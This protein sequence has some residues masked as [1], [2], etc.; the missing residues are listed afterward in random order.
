MDGK[1]NKISLLKVGVWKMNLDDIYRQLNEKERLVIDG[2]SAAVYGYI[3]INANDNDENT[4]R[5]EHEQVLRI[6]QCVDS[7]WE[8]VDYDTIVSEI[9]DAVKDKVVIEDLMAEV[10]KDMPLNIVRRIHNRLKN[11]GVKEGIKTSKGC[12]FISIPGSEP[13][14]END[15]L[16]YVR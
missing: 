1:S 6:Y 11:P 5:M 2:N 12:Y 8:E 15:E 13:G 14:M 3:T 10:L 7:E 16:I 9:T 4:L